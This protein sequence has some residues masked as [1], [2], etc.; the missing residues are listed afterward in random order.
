MYEYVTRPICDMIWWHTQ[1]R[2]HPISTKK[3][4]FCTRSFEIGEPQ[5]FMSNRI[6][7]SSSPPSTVDL[8]FFLDGHILKKYSVYE[9]S[10]YTFQTDFSWKKSLASVVLVLWLSTLTTLVKH[11]CSHFDA[12]VSS[13]CSRD[14]KRTCFLFSYGRT[15]YWRQQIFQTFSTLECTHKFQKRNRLVIYEITR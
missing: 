7:T 1:E 10:C 9:V 12:S 4:N 6:S 5:A 11:D 8:N 15:H 13:L 2:Q 3:G 14:L